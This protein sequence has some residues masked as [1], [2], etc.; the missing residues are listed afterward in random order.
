MLRKGKTKVLLTILNLTGGVREYEI[1]LSDFSETGRLCSGNQRSRKVNL[2]R[3]TDHI[4]PDRWCLGKVEPLLILTDCVTSSGEPT[5]SVRYG[6]NPLTDWLCW[7]YRQCSGKVKHLFDWLCEPDRR[8]SGQGKPFTN[9]VCWTWQVVLKAEGKVHSLTLRDVQLNE[10]GQ[11]K[12]TAK[13]FQAEANLIVKGKMT[14]TD[15]TGLWWLG[16]WWSV[17]RPGCYLPSRFNMQLN[18]LWKSCFCWPPVMLRCTPGCIRTLWHHCWVWLQVQQSALLTRGE[19]QL[20]L[21]TREGNNLLFSL[22]FEL[23]SKQQISSGSSAWT[24][25]ETQKSL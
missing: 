9:W 14:S 4:K 12:L 6:L 16:W 1:V 8:G 20:K 11:V 19:T 10:A 21:S 25:L 15:S 2:H 24:F 23:L 18:T 13:D 5:A 22:V 3:V 7:T 17:V